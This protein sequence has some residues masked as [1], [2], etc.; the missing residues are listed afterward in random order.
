[1]EIS[2]PD[3]PCSTIPHTLNSTFVLPR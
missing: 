3:L 1:A 2:W